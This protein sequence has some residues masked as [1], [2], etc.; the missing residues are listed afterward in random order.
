[1]SAILVALVANAACDEGAKP[2]TTG[3]ATA[4][5]T[6]T[7]TGTTGPSASA[8]GSAAAKV[9]LPKAPPLPTQPAFFSKM[10]TPKD[11]ELTPERV[12]LGKMLFFDKRL[13]KDDKWACE[14]C[15]YVDKG[16][17]DGTKVSTKADGKDNGRH[18]PTLVNVAFANEWYWDGR[19][20]TLEA[21]ILAAWT[22][23]MGG[24]P[25]AVAAKLV[26]IPEYKAHFQRAYKE[27]PSGDNIV[28]ALA[29]F[30][31]TIWAGEA[32]YD[33]FEKGDKEAVD[34]SAQRGFNVFTKKANCSLCH[35]PPMYTDYKYHNV[36]IGFGEG[37]N[38]DEGRG[39][40][41][42][43]DEEKGA[44]KTPTLR[45]VALHAP[46][47][48]DGSAATLEEAVDYMLTGFHKNDHLDEQLKEVKLS[49][50]EKK[51]LIAFLNALTPE[52]KFEKPKLP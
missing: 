21:Q 6:A 45:G 25:K 32:P 14:S 17:A 12:M 41:T 48:H 40:V 50:D 42:K 33:K 3:G 39:K 35:A 13:G 36:G 31:R 37:G 15:H 8:S 38:K 34:E 23:Q 43:K 19:K 4:T 22:G 18:S 7:N 30:V 52:V 20:A 51:D 5:S 27:A 11:N 10:K 28:K 24:D 9:E 29:S 1:M 16:W 49:D 46:Y 2:A 47:F 44:F 26:K